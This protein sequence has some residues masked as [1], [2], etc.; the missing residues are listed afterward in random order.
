M[1]WL[2]RIAV[3]ACML[4]LLAALGIATEHVEAGLGSLYADCWFSPRSGKLTV[5]TKNSEQATLRR[6][7]KRVDVLAPARTRCKGGRATVRKTSRIRFV[8][9]GDGITEGHVSL[10]GGAFG[11]GRPREPDGTSEIEINVIVPS[12]ESEFQLDGT[13]GSDYLRG[14]TLAGAAAV[15]LNPGVEP[16]PDADLTIGGRYGGFGGFDLKDGDDVLDLAGGPE[17]ESPMAADFT[18][19]GPG[20]DR[21]T[22]SS[23]FDF[24]LAGPGFDSISA[25]GGDD[26]VNSLDGLAETVDCGDGQDRVQPDP[27]DI[28]V[29]CEELG[30]VG[31][32]D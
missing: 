14:G 5:K 31:I 17:F 10:A 13:T 16:A 9:K 3:S 21:F 24:V 25:Q 15:N 4:A 20:N 27:T 22:G 8:L 6:H 26:W 11:P 18:E 32:G 23:G 7:G 2:G 28:L 29:S 1:S 30:F 19:L 12:S